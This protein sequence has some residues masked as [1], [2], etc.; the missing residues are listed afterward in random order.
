MFATFDP[1][2]PQLLSEAARR[3]A[4]V[5]SSCEEPG[6]MPIRAL[7]C[8]C[9]AAVK[10]TH[11]C[12]PRPDDHSRR[13][14]ASAPAPSQE[15]RNLQIPESQRN[16][17]P[18]PPL[19]RRDGFGSSG[20][21]DVPHQSSLFMESTCFDSAHATLRVRWARSRLEGSLRSIMRGQPDRTNAIVPSIKWIAGDQIENRL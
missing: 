8:G 21:K 9:H 4:P 10:R 3:A 6:R 17:I 13:R 5:E 14:I 18:T 20:P 2:E 7:G 11:R 16:W 1:S 15:L 12:P 19:P